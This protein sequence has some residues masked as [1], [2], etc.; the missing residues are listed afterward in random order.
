VG[1]VYEADDNHYLALCSIIA[2]T[3]VYR[4]SLD[5]ISCYLGKGDYPI[6]FS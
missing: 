2:A 4:R 3:E 6:K 1:T 5:G